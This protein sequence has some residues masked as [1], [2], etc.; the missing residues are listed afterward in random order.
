MIF[1]S[2]DGENIFF[3]A[4]TLNWNKVYPFGDYSSFA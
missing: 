4:H 1:T 3:I 2:N